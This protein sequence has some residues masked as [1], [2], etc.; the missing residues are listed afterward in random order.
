MFSPRSIFGTL[1]ALQ[2]VLHLIFSNAFYPFELQTWGAIFLGFTFFYAGTFLSDG[3]FRRGVL[4]SK[5]NQKEKLNNL[6]FFL[7]CF[8]CIYLFAALLS[9]MELYATL[10]EMGADG[11]NFPVIRQIVVLDFDGDRLLYGLFRVFYLGV[12]FCIFFVAS[13]KEITKKQLIM[14]LIIGLVS[15][16]L[17][18]GRLYLLLYFISIAALLYRER[19]ISSK[20]VL[21]AGLIFLSLFFLVALLLGKGDDDGTASLFENVLWNSQVYFMSSIS[22][23]ND[24]LVSN[25]QNIDGGALL[26]NP[27]RDFL[28]NFG[29]SIPLKPALNPFSYVPVPCNTYTYLFPLYHD[30]SFF[31]V[32]FGSFMIGA[33]HQF[34]YLK[35]IFTNSPIWGY[36]YA[37]SIYALLMTIFE[38]AYFSSPGFWLL[39]MIPPAAYYAYYWVKLNRPMR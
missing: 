33:F 19:F 34:L 39:L 28:S 37:I 26:P 11:L 36:F 14:V 32:I 22:C 8:L 13:S 16:L 10:Q 2:I 12:G 4:I 9:A 35:F 20:G 38:D 30:G 18:T 5:H 25:S 21:L 24:Y 6:T 17:T 29:M 15:A 7:N 23:F 1:W 27:I 3:I 31:G